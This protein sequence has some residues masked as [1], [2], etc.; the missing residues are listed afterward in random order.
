MK[1]EKAPKGGTYGKNGEWYKG[2]QFLPSSEK[3]VK[4]AIKIKKGSGK[5][6]IAPYIWERPLDDNMVSIYDRIESH[7]QDNRK[8]C[9]YVKGEGFIGLQLRAGNLL[10]KGRSLS[11]Y[12]EYSI[13]QAKI[14]WLMGLVE[15]FN[16]GERWFALEMDPFHYKNDDNR[17][18]AYNFWKNAEM[19]HGIVENDDA[20][21]PA[22]VADEK[23]GERDE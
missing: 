14:N 9:E 21:Y 16:N 19:D 22:W 23:Q 20:E 4:G 3:T 10:A 15:A 17:K 2:G 8:E 7:V 11:S 5:R 13:G 18:E 1:M 6:V 12:G